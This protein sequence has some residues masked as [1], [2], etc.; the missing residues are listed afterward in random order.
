ML[1][2][3]ASQNVRDEVVGLL[4]VCGNRYP[5]VAVPLRQNAVPRSNRQRVYFY[6]F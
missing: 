4:F 6:D 2:F 5:R 1:Q 3:Y